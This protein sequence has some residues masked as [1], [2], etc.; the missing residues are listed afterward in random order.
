M[1]GT[2]SRL[3]VAAGRKGFKAE[4]EDLRER[5]R[6]LAL[7]HEQIAGEIARRYRT[8]PREAYRLAHGWT[9]GQAAARFNARAAELGTDRDGLAGLAASRLCEFEKWPHSERRPS[10]YVLVMLAQVYQAGVLSLL[11]LDDHEHLPPHDRLALQQTAGDA[12]RPGTPP[13]GPPLAGGGAVSLSLPWVPARLVIEVD[14]PALSTG[15][16][17]STGPAVPGPVLPAPL[18]AA[19]TAV[20]ASYGGR[21]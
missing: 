19:I 10:V 21:A 9:L 3:S 12:A 15:P 2:V 20:P 5:M 13:P 4:L 7:G 1:T 16:C 6:G 8:R 17:G 11:D 14:G 18:P